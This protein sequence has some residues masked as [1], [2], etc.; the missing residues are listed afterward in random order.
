MGRTLKSPL[1]GELNIPEEEVPFSE[2]DLEKEVALWCALLGRF[3][4]KDVLGRVG[5]Y[6]RESQGLN[7]SENRIREKLKAFLKKEGI[8]Y[9]GTE[10]VIPGERA[11]SILHDFSPEEVRERVLFV[12]ETVRDEYSLLFR[13]REGWI[14]SRGLLFVPELFPE[15]KER[16]PEWRKPL[17]EIGSFLPLF[18][19]IF[20]KVSK[21]ILLVV[22]EEVLYRAFVWAEGPL[23]LWLEALEKDFP[24]QNE[25]F[26]WLLFQGALLAGRKNLALNLKERLATPWRGAYAEA[27]VRFL[28]GEAYISALKEAEELFRAS[29]RRKYFLPDGPLGLLTPL[30]NFLSRDPERQSSVAHHWS[31]LLRRVPEDWREEV[32]PLGRFLRALVERKTVFVSWEEPFSLEGLVFLWLEALSE[33]DHPLFKPD[34]AAEVARELEE[35]GHLLWALEILG[36][37]SRHHSNLRS[38][39]ERLSERIGFRPIIERFFEEPSWEERLARLERLLEP[40]A[41]KDSE[42]DNKRLVW[43]FQLTKYGFILEPVEQKRLAPGL[44]SKGRKVSLKRLYEGKYPL[45]NEHDRRIAQ[46]I[47]EEIIGYGRWG[48]VEYTFRPEVLEAL[49]GHPLV[50]DAR[51]GEHLEVEKLRPKLL[52]ERIPEGVRVRIKP[53]VSPENEWHLFR[54]GTRLWILRLDEPLRE[55][56]LLVGKDG[57][58]VPHEAEER[59]Q[60]I[61]PGLGRWLEVEAEVAL[62]EGRKVPPEKKLGLFL[63]P[64]AEGLKLTVR[65]LPLGEEG[66]RFVPGRGREEVLARVGDEVLRTRRDL[67]TERERFQILVQR[68]DQIDELEKLGEAEWLAPDLP[69]ALEL[70]ETLSELPQE[71]YRIFWP[72][73][74]RL[75]V[76]AVTEVPEVKFLS[77]GEWFEV[78]GRLKL[79]E[80]EI[81]LGE[82][83]KH[84][85]ESRG[86][87]VPLEEGRFLALKEEIYRGLKELAELAEIRRNRTLIHPLKALALREEGLR[88]EGDEG[89]RE[90]RRR[91]EAVFNEN[92]D[93]P[94]G[95]RAELRPYQLEGYRWLWRLYRLG[96]GGCLADDMGLG[97]TVQTL[98]L[99]LA[100]AEKGP[101]LVVAPAS[102]LSVWQEETRKFAP[103]L[104]LVP[105]AEV[106]SR[107]AALERASPGEVFLVSYG[108]LQ[109]EETAELLKR[110]SWNVV[111]LDEAQHIKNYRTKRAR[112]AYALSAR[113][114]LA[115]TGTPVENRLEELWALFRFL[116]PG[117]LGSHEEF[118]RRFVIPIEKEKN[119]EARRR[120]RRIIKPFLLRRTKAEVLEDLP[121][122]TE[123]TVPVA[124]SPEEKRYYEI[125]RLKALQE[126]EAADRPEKKRFTLLSQLTRLRLFCASPRLVFPEEALPESK[127]ETLL[128]LLEEALSAGHRVLVF[129]QF[130]KFLRR[131]EEALRERSMEYLSLYGSTPSAERARRVEDFRRGTVRIFL[132]SLKAGGFGLNL[133]VADHVI[134]CDPWWNPAVELQATDRVHRLGQSRPVTIYRLVTRDTVEEKVQTLQQEKRDLAE[135]LL[136]ETGP[137]STLDWETLL[138]LLR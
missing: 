133:T 112:H 118:R 104:R 68:L 43:F 111:V 15:V 12:R 122:K 8:S 42:K 22:L 26:F 7:L 85:G 1:F 56:L 58:V 101:S 50:F 105:L 48:R 62:A 23:P 20:E 130:V 82:V 17:R 65:S 66:P 44:W 4:Q 51:T 11:L 41:Q 53:W 16:F 3:N 21:E 33:E 31:H 95:L 29:S 28:S 89:W 78:K 64:M 127:L 14:L 46:Y 137:P 94:S 77:S 10:Y 57:L 6:L 121:P 36:A 136:S 108:L 90:F 129:S 25:D 45:K 49:A 73:G 27:L 126:I 52:V 100:V 63:R 98:A 115:T 86:R 117:F 88:T 106:E 55:I 132:L 135:A 59:L 30:M 32:A 128:E 35:D 138:E 110:V 38:E 40:E 54:E 125:L 47:Q 13:P 70:L 24:Y 119:A 37:L 114:R 87:F 116:N 107:S 5:E 39:A 123:V 34:G 19:E 97:K 103:D 60:R 80:G 18:P 99:L 134:L 76:E 61:L 92:P 102:V 96:F 69:S 79:A 2:E 81:D 124:L 109:Q 75:R 74:E 67:F 131:L 120:L 83:L 72:E 71:V 9:R 84:L 91:L 113:F 93:P